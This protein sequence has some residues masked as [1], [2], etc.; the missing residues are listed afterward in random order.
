LNYRSNEWTMA[1]HWALDRLEKLFPVEVFAKMK[2]ASCNPSI[3]IDAGGD[4][5]IIHGETGALM[6]GVPYAKGLRVPRSKMRALSATG[7]EVQVSLFTSTKILFTYT[8]S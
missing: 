1:I 6:T 3:P 4:Y 5:P 2:E 7:I 8:A